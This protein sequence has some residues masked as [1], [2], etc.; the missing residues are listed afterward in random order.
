MFLKEVMTYFQT[1]L[2]LIHTYIFYK[3][4]TYKPAG[5]RLLDF[6]ISNGIFHYLLV[7]HS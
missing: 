3:H 4:V 6:H 1:G 2:N 5:W 7:L